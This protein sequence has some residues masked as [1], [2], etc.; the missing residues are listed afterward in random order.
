MEFDCVSI[1]ETTEVRGQL[2]A[3]FW[4]LSGVIHEPWRMTSDDQ[5]T[6]TAEIFSSSLRF[7]VQ[8]PSLLPWSLDF[9]ASNEVLA[10]KPCLMFH[11][12]ELLGGA[13]SCGCFDVLSVSSQLSVDA[14]LLFFFGVCLIDG[15]IQLYCCGGAN[16][17]GRSSCTCFFTLS[18]CDSSVYK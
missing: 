14:N 7:L 15:I 12:A 18:H 2:H 11:F 13:N 6:S 17:W 5:A 9:L 16:S 10:D 8:F 3:G 1:C 4:P